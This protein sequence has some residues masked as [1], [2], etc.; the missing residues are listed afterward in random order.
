[1]KT[2]HLWL[3]AAVAL[4]AIAGANCLRGVSL[5]VDPDVVQRGEKV[6]L[7]CNYDLENAPLYSL[8]WYRGRHEFYRFSPTE[9]SSTKTFNISGINVDPD[10]SN[11]SQ[12][13]LR[14]VDFGL[15]G[16]FI[17]EVTADA[18]TFS[19]ASASKNLTVVFLP[20]EEP[21]IVSERDRY[22]PGDM[23]RA[24]CS[25]PPSKPPV[26]ISFT[27]NSMPLKA[28][29]R[30]QRT[31]EDEG[32][33]WSEISLTLQPFHY[34]NGRLNLRCTAEIPGVYSKQ[35]ELQLLSGMRE[36]VPERVTSEN[37]SG[38]HTMTFVTIL[39]LGTLHLLLR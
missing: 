28:T 29:T 14:N 23:L 18:P 31:K 8:K 32:M 10:K 35:S 4:L 15:S 34:T 20:R 38:M 39:C 11:N 16:T 19:T 12:V 21:V 3:E 9:E 33:Q 30:Q 25:L 2:C 7:R 37:G 1:M 5:E 22:D 13:T 17:C 26:H 27:L 6:I 24:N 36:P